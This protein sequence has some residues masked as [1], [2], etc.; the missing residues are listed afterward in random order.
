[1]QVAQTKND[2][3][4]AIFVQRTKSF[5]K[6]QENYLFSKQLL[7]REEKKQFVLKA[8]EKTI[9]SWSNCCTE[10]KQFVLQATIAQRRK[11]TIYS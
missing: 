5:F 8:K 2:C 10:K 6:Q 7:H 11:N 4:K 3:Q 1:M 9:C